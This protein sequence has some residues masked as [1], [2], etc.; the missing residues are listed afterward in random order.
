MPR[1]QEQ[2]Y[3]IKNSLIHILKKSYL[4]YYFI[5]QTRITISQLKYKPYSSKEDSLHLYKQLKFY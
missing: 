3:S 5:V 2:N 1:L 4:F